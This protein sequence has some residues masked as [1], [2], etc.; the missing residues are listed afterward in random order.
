MSFA[1]FISGI[2][3]Y[4]PSIEEPK[5]KPAL[6]SRLKYSFLI[7][8]L[9]FILGNIPIYG[10]TA[11]AASNLAVYQMI[12]ASNIGTLLTVGIGPIVV[13]SIVLQLLVG[14]GIWNLDFADPQARVLFSSTQ[15]ILAI[16]LSF[17]EA[18]VYVKVGFLTPTDGMFIW[19]LL[20]VALGSIILLY[21]D[22]IVTKYGI[23]SG[24]SLFIAGNV[25]AGIFWRILS[26]VSTIGVGF[27]VVA[28][29]SALDLASGAGLLWR[30]FAELG[31]SLY[32]SLVQ[33]I[34]PI[35]F[36]L[37]IFFVIVYFEGVYVNIPITMGRSSQMG[38]YPVKFFYV[39]NLPV[40]LAA[41]L[42]ANIALLY[43]MV[44]K[45]T[46]PVLTTVLFF[47][48][49]YT[50]APT[51]LTQNILLQGFGG[52]GGQILQAI[53]YMILLS[54]TCVFFGIMWVKMAGQDSEA[55]SKQLQQSGMYLPGFRRDPRVIKSVL[56]RYIPTITILG[57]I[58]VGFL[59]AFANITSAVG[60]GM[61][62]LLTVDIV[63]RLYEDIVKEQVSTDT[64]LLSKLINM[65]KY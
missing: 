44:Q 29:G 54:V 48:T 35:V 9:F 57:S 10:L 38:R 24:I 46:I 2:S 65:K 32:V 59:A 23:G 53:I 15:K 45:T 43:A 47:L 58:F 55:V 61:G 13:A 39:S 36:T 28:T 17:F 18:F 60:T 12:L 42:F 41:A 25:A 20:Q 16:I 19:V 14:T 49:K 37:L 5:S 30:F 8:V 51:Q 40:I 3:K 52:L 63:Y 6:G 34:F 27:K 62:I 64:G 56:D 33:N 31:S 4:I 21:F 50:T 1:T 11:S 22:E 26:P 7:L